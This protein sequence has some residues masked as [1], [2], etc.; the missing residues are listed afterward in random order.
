MTRHNTELSARHVLARQISKLL[1]KALRAYSLGR[2][3]QEINDIHDS[4]VDIK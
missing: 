1:P 2:M 4:L 3:M